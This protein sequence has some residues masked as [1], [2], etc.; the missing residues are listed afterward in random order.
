MEYG[1]F[2]IKMQYVPYDE[3]NEPNVIVDGAANAHTVLTLSHWPDSN[4][5][6]L[7]KD[8]LSAQI[9]FHYLDR[10]ELQVSASIVSNN[11]FDQD[12]LIGIYCLLDPSAAQSQRAFLID[13]AAAGDFATYQF[14]EAARVAFVLAAFADPDLSSLDPTIFRERY[15]TMAGRLYQE[16]LPRLPEI[17]N[18]TDQFRSYWEHEDAMLNESEAMIRNGTIQIEEI[19]DLDLAVVTLPESLPGRKAH[20]FTSNRNAVCHPMALN[21][22][23]RSFRVLL[24]QGQSYELQYRYE[25]WVQYISRKPLPRIDLTPLADEFSAMEQ[26]ASRWTFNGVDQI[27]PAL[28][29]S[30]SEQSCIPPETFRSHVAEFL[31]AKRKRDSAQPGEM[32]VL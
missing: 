7:L 30:G 22:V 15:P 25:S 14:R 28:T 18:H 29:L 16:L 2:E 19:P 21:N 31:K 11:H 12:G 23:I 3:I 20:R 4:T 26:G 27:T 13:I 17:V 1:S 6:K 32:R 9:V 8:D 5:P 10:P 24:M